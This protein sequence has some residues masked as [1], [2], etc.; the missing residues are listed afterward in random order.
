MIFNTIKKILLWILDV[1]FLLMMIA[2]FANGGTFSGILL[3]ISIIITNPLILDK[4]P[5]LNWKATAPISIVLFFISIFTFPTNSNND[6]ITANQQIEETNTT[7]TSVVEN[8]TTAETTEIS[9]E[10]TTTSIVTTTIETTITTEPITTIMETTQSKLEEPTEHNS[11]AYVDYLYYKAKQDIKT[12][13]QDEALEYIKSNIDNIFNS[14]EIMEKCMYYGNILSIFNKDTNNNNE[15]I[16]FYT[17]SSIK[18]VYRGDESIEDDDTQENLN[19]LRNLLEVKVEITTQEITSIQETE[20]Q[21][22]EEPQNNDSQSITVYITP[23]GEKYHYDG[24]CGN[25]TYIPIDL[26]E[27]ISKGYEPCKKCS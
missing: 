23:T 10:I 3:L 26:D 15:Q 13:N 20:L 8:T 9:T 16:G 18:Y 11:S 14:N 4:I 24:N 25:G 12:V 17:V 2:G 1:F 22:I 19:K 5:K 7:S 6:T 21:E 27:A